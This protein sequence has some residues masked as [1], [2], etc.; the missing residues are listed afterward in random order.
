MLENR[1]YNDEKNR[2]K[3]GGLKFMIV[4]LLLWC[5]SLSNNI[6]QLKTEINIL[7]NNIDNSLED[8]QNN[9]D[10]YHQE[11]DDEGLDIGW[12][13]TEMDWNKKQMKVEF[14]IYPEYATDDATMKIINYVG[15]MALVREGDAF[16]GSV[17][18]PI[19]NNYKTEVVMY[20]GGE[21]IDRYTTEKIGFKAWAMDEVMCYI[22]GFKQYGNGKYTFA[23]DVEYEIPITEE[24]KKANF[25]MG[26]KTME[27][28]K[29]TKG[30]FK[31][32]AS[33]VVNDNL[34]KN[35]KYNLADIYVELE[36]VD[37]VIY[38]FYPEMDICANYSVAIDM[39][40][41]GTSMSSGGT[42]DLSYDDYLYQDSLIVVILPDG[43]QYEAYI[44]EE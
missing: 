31:V 32:N 25:V 30:F 39:S 2:G 44:A 29:A 7:N 41:G 42:D 16:V 12:H 19:E 28:E 24:I 36:N 18:Y 3:N 14:E 37:G 9:I 4:I 34:I 38:R 1:V 17:W 21:E 22:S 35:G 11:N 10:L 23:G 27:I 43:T 33:E 20:E 15:E 26:E 40:D 13:V 6:N 8:I 5:M